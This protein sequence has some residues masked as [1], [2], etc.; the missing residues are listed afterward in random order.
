MQLQQQPKPKSGGTLMEFFLL[1]LCSGVH[2]ICERPSLSLLKQILCGWFCM[3]V[4]HRGGVEAR[5]PKT[6][7]KSTSSVVASPLFFSFVSNLLS[8]ATHFVSYSHLL[9]P[10][11]LY[12]LC[13]CLLLGFALSLLPLLLLL[14]LAFQCLYPLKCY[15]T[16]ATAWCAQPSGARM[17]DDFKQLRVNREKQEAVCSCK[18]FLRSAAVHTYTTCMHFC[19]HAS[20]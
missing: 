20:K 15:G 12:G 7:R 17:I 1:P 10:V 13:F 6:H 4:G 14:A 2:E 19:M 11:C 3:S 9:V 16:S 8:M 5:K 18:H